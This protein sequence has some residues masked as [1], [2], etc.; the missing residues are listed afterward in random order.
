MKEKK[1]WGLRVLS[2]VQRLRYGELLNMEEIGVLVFYD[3]TK[4]VDNAERI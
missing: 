3:D 2:R 1:K 4:Q